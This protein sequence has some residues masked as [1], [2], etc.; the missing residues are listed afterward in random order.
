MADDT[1]TVLIKSGMERTDELAA[2]G[3]DADETDVTAIRK[4]A[5]SGQ[6]LVYEL[7]VASAVASASRLGQQTD[8]AVDQVKAEGKAM[9][10]ADPATVKAVTDVEIAEQR[11]VELAAKDAES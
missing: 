5:G 8:I 10:N 6:E 7:L 1:Q 11:A 3:A 2:T 9:K 4:G